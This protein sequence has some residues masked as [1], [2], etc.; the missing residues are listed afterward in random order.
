MLRLGSFSALAAL[1]VFPPAGVGQDGTIR[2]EGRAWVRVLTGTAQPRPRLRVLGHGPVTLQGGARVNVAYTVKVRVEARS[3]AEARRMLSGA[4]VRVSYERGELLIVAPGGAALSAVTIAGPR[5]G[6]VDIATTD[7]AVDARGVDGSLEVNSGAGE[8]YADQI[9][10]NCVLM[11][12]GGDVRVGEV[13]AGLRCRTGAGRITVTSAGGQA[14]LETDGGDI[15]AQRVGGA[16]RA[17]TGAG[18]V[19]VKF[20]GGP[21]NAVTGGGEIVVDKANGIVTARNMGGPVRVDGAAG[22]QCQNTSGGVRVVNID[23]AMRVSTAMGSIFATLLAGK[24]ADSFLATGNGDITV[25]IPSNVGV[26]IRASNRMADSV[27]RI[28]SD[29]PSI[30][31]RRIGTEVV[32]EGAVNGGGPVLRIAGTGGTIFIKH[33]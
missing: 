13:R 14:V 26:T 11:T 3:E 32:A 29:F 16:V 4:A 5:F 15:V 30:A 17:Q 22:V 1:L 25:M 12:G 21:V 6:G 23:G 19:E 7:G 20:A 2:R 10:G 28:V 18:R 24:L 27:R 9:H 31:A 33:L 8:I